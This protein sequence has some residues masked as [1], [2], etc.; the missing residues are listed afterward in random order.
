MTDVTVQVVEAHLRPEPFADRWVVLRGYGYSTLNRTDDEGKLFLWGG[1]RAI[2]STFLFP[3]TSE[4]AMRIALPDERPS[5]P[6]ALADA[7][8]SPFTLREEEGLWVLEVEAPAAEGEYTPILRD[9]RITGPVEVD[10]EGAEE[11]VAKIRRRLGELGFDD[12]PVT[13]EKP[14]KLIENYQE[15]LKNLESGEEKVEATKKKTAE[16]VRA[17]KIKEFKAAVKNYEQYPRTYEG[18]LRKLLN[19]VLGVS[20]G[21][22][23]P[24]D[25]A[26]KKRSWSV[27][28]LMNSLLLGG[29][30]GDIGDGPGND[31]TDVRKVRER[32]WAAGLLEWADIERAECDE[33]LVEAIRSF[34]KRHA[35][36]LDDEV[37]LE[38][39]RAGKQNGVVVPGHRTH[40]IL[41]G[42]RAP[43]RDAGAPVPAGATPHAFAIPQIIQGEP[44]GEDGWKGLWTCGPT[45]VA[46]VTRYLAP[47][48]R[49]GYSEF[50]LTFTLC[51]GG[52]ELW[53]YPER[54][55]GTP[56]NLCMLKYVGLEG[57][58][59]DATSPDS[60]VQW[61]EARLR[62]G[63]VV[64]TNGRIGRRPWK[65]S[66]TAGGH[67]MVISG[68]WEHP[69]EGAVFLV[70]DPGGR[71]TGNQFMTDE[72]LA[73]WIEKDDR[74]DSQVAISP[75]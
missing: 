26:G 53:S 10:L 58:R 6:V 40:K 22:V 16:E 59:S 27:L 23:V 75:R 46:M 31:P 12:A 72:Q 44:R 25:A 17:D 36:V 35:D 54:G 71:T 15:R 13:V 30:V 48:A 49:R 61:I 60:A 66:E 45:S 67:F 7:E 39:A 34:Q 33:A 28:C 41:N 9:F 24:D 4:E 20:K 37:K 69:S 57:V 3:G 65:E 42:L 32:L 18:A 29:P 47:A 5:D 11:D 64:I 43:A 19:E 56:Y 21:Q 68:L 74:G 63:D 2:S 70:Q 8:F 62:A 38:K 52:G 55:S 73:H 1:D 14:E 51:E 50:E